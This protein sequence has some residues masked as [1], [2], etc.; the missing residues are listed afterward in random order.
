[1]APWGANFVIVF[2]GALSL[3]KETMMVLFL[4]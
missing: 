2:V 3:L 4:L 1:M